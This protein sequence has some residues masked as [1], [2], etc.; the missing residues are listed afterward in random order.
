[1][2]KIHHPYHLWEDYQNGM[3][4][5]INGKAR[6]IMLNKAITFTGNHELYG[7][8]MMKVIDLWTVS[9]EH[10]LSDKN[11][12]KRA[13]IG[14]AACCLAIQCPEDITR[15]AWGCLS[16]AQQVAADE[17]A[18]NAIKAWNE[19]QNIKLHQEMGKAGVSTRN[20]R[21]S[22]IRFND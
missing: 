20:T 6:R 17:Q 2:K 7:E 19:K 8:Y 10:N 13:W 22:T 16:K 3:Y 18:D 12:N 11:M 15:Q 4:E 14:H 9:C 1:M 21:R 5:S